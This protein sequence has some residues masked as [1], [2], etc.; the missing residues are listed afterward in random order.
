MKPIRRLIIRDKSGDSLATELNIVIA[1]TFW[2]RLVGLLG[3]SALAD[4]EGLLLKPCT[5]IHTFGMKFPID[6]VFVD[7][8]MK[9]LGFSDAVPPNKLRFSPRGTYAVLEVADG[10]RKRTGINLDDYLIFD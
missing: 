4:H 5:D 1:S 3:R 10:N 2:S 8:R 7:N 6:V 9:V